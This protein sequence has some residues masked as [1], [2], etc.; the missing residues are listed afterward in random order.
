MAQ[1]HWRDPYR[2]AVLEVDLHPLKF[3]VQAAEDAIR[4]RA[5]AMAKSPAKSASPSKSPRPL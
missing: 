5:E 2:A 3:R 1:N 4:A